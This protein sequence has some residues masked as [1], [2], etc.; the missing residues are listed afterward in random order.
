[1]KRFCLGCLLLLCLLSS[2]TDAFRRHYTPRP[3]GISTA[4]G[5]AARAALPREA[6]IRFD[7]YFLEAVRQKQ[8]EHLDAA[9]EL[10][11][12]ALAINPDAPEAL[13]EM[14]RIKYTL[15]PFSDSIEVGEAD[16]MLA[17]AVALEP[18]NK[19]YREMLAQ[20]YASMGD[21]P[22]AI[23]LYERLVGDHPSAEGYEFLTRLYEANGDYEGAIRALSRLETMEGPCEE[24]SLEK[25]KI[26][27][28]MGDSTNAYTAI[29]DLCAAYPTDLR[30]RV[31]LGNLHMQNGHR[32]Q[33]HRL[34][35]D[36]LTA[37]PNNA[38]AQISTLA[39]YK[40]I[41]ADSLY[42]AMMDDVLLNPNTTSEARAEVM[43]A[44]T[45]DAL[46][47]HRDSTEVLAVCEQALGYRM[48][49]PAIGEICALYIGFARLPETT[50]TLPLSAIL[51]DLPDYAPA[52][53]QLLGIRL[54]QED[55]DAVIAL[56]RDGQIYNPGNTVFYFYEGIAEHT[57]GNFKAAVDAYTR[58][59]V[60]IDTDSQ[61]D[62]EMA[63]E[64]Y[65]ALGDAQHSLGHETEAFA[66]YDRALQYN[67][68]NITCLNNYAYYLSLRAQDLDRAEQM[69]RKTVEQEPHNATYLDTYAWILYLKRQYT[70]ARIYIDE[71]L[72]H[73]EDGASSATYY[74]HA[75]DIY[76]RCGESKTAVRYWQEALKTAEKADKNKLR[77]KIRRKRI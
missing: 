50:M 2:C 20:R 22:H 51:R 37:E 41:G 68:D 44:Y 1:M 43:R 48:D 77:S 31:L 49:T 35:T 28:E 17:R 33:A 24:Y 57:R 71:A 60:H 59:A 38:F 52:R 34:Y 63:A 75:G 16:K 42:Q 23:A 14:A 64:Y 47:T 70:Q 12:R 19:Y 7:Q 56:C 53:L 72:K 21:F 65:T 13:F 40:A 39:Y 4:G 76:Y 30:Y 8:G 58:G 3:R 27:S 67:A 15:S 5:V 62:T 9:Y 74:D 66:A 46:N 73:L 55:I 29:E 10:L 6:Q 25:F 36:V 26:Y 54:G 69:S 18:A 11:G 61:Y 45:L 32:E